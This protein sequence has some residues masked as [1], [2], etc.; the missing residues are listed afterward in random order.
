MND[1]DRDWG[2]RAYV[3]LFLEERGEQVADLVKGPIQQVCVHLWNV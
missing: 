1:I 3:T 2:V